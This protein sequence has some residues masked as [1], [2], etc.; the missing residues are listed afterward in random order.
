MPPSAGPGR[1]PWPAT[2]PAATTACAA[3]RG[4]RHY[5]RSSLRS[6]QSC[7]RRALAAPPLKRRGDR[8]WVVVSVTALGTGRRRGRSAPVRARW[9][10]SVHGVLLVAVVGVA[11]ASCLYAGHGC[12]PVTQLPFCNHG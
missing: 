10:A 7:R 8:C 5:R 12:S 1:P 6:T 4:V 9:R 2:P 3:A 11:H